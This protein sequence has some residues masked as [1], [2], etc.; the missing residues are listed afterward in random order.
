MWHKI[1]LKFINLLFKI[2]KIYNNITNKIMK[3]KF[4]L[5]QKYIYY[6]FIVL[7]L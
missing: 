1:G 3:D 2:I 6:L 7:L 4:S 5:Y